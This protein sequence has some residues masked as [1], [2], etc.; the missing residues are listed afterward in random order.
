VNIALKNE[1]WAAPYNPRL[2]E[3]VL[4]HT[5]SGATYRLPLSS[6]PRR[7]EPGTSVTLSQNVTL[8]AGMATGT[9]ALLLNLPDA[10][11]AL[12]TRPEYAI[13][14]ANANVWEASTG[15]NSLQ[16]TVTVQ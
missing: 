4:R 8:P 16:R 15:F 1:G 3:L 13:Q 2:A 10:A 11:A 9:Y 6:D 14:L 12:S 5:S 7:W